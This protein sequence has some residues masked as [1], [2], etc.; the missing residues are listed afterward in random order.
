M[1]VFFAFDRALDSARAEMLR[2]RWDGPDRTSSG[3]CDDSTWAS[4][5]MRGVEGVVDWVQSEMV[6]S[7]VV[8]VLIGAETTFCGHVKTAI[9]RGVEAGLG[10]VGIRVHQIPGADGMRGMPGPDPL[11]ALHAEVTTHDWMPGFSDRF[12]TDWVYMAAQRAGR[13]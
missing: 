11:F 6:G 4:V 5:Q 10:V 12:L 1:N 2:E 7:D 3:F 9:E 13:L 8:V